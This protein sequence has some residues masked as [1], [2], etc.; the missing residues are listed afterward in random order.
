MA[1]KFEIKTS[2]SGQVH[3]NLK[4]GNGQIIL[5][6]EM[7]ETKAAAENGI[8]SVR[9]NSA[10]DARYERKMSSNGKPY[11]N[12]KASNGQVIGRS[13]MYESESAMENGIR[14][15]KEN[16]PDASTADA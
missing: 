8:D 10:D 1:G 3:F 15:V 13:E 4:A 2:A 11:F 7:Y 16:A 9:R 14:S 12:L 5:S 6:S